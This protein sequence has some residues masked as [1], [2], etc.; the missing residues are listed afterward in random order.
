MDLRDLMLENVR[1][2]LYKLAKIL[3]SKY[4]RLREEL[5]KFLGRVIPA[6]WHLH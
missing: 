6:F 2:H 3:S 1:H 5:A 4:L